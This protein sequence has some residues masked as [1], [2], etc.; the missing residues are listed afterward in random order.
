VVKDGEEE[1]RDGYW[2]IFDSVT[3]TTNVLS[4][5]NTRR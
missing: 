5:I 1:R 3:V 2:E 4:D